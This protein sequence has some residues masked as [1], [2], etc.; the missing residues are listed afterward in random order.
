MENLQS[1]KKETIAELDKNEIG[2]SLGFD[3]FIKEYRRMHHLSDK[4]I[5]MPVKAIKSD[6]EIVAGSPKLQLKKAKIK[7]FFN[8]IYK[9]KSPDEYINIC[10]GDKTNNKEGTFFKSFF[11][12]DLDKLSEF[13]AVHSNAR[14][15]TY[16]RLATTDGNGGTEEHLKYRYSLGF[17]FDNKDFGRELKVTDIYDSVKRANNKFYYHQIVDSGNGYHLYVIITKTD[18]LDRV[19]IL[20]EEL[21]KSLGA[22]SKAVLQTQ[23]LRVPYTYNIKDKVK[24][25]T[26]IIPLEKVLDG[27]HPIKFD[28]L[29]ARYCRKQ[30]VSKNNNL[31]I[32][33]SRLRDTEN[34]TPCLERML[35]E[36]SRVKERTNDLMHIVFLL[37]EQYKYTY[38]QINAVCL[39]WGIKSDFKDNIEYRIKYNYKNVKAPV[40]CKDCKDY[41]K[42]WYTKENKDILLS[43]SDAGVEKEV[44]VELSES[45]AKKLKV[46]GTRGVELL[47]ASSLLVFLVLKTTVRGLERDKIVEILTNPDTND[48]A[49]GESTITKA[50][51]NLE[52]IGYI[53]VEVKKNNKK[54]YKVKK[55]RI[56]PD[57]LFNI[58][59]S[60]VI[61]CINN[62]ITKDE[63]KFY[64]YL[65]YLL[66]KT[67]KEIGENDS[68]S[69]MLRIN[70]ETIS[71]DYGVSQQ[72]I[73]DMIANLRKRKLILISEYGISEYNGFIYYTYTLT[74]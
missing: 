19:G 43:D 37:K 25:V 23:L 48:V 50:L 27:F 67:N 26:P 5:P 6:S 70:Q 31:D 71:K 53:E 35:K 2:S 32:N 28:L 1:I 40:R 38:P 65:K 17:D 51:N 4:P 58:N 46:L 62:L 57:L 36:G 3:N 74:C 47:D 30:G 55:T 20:Q 11:F 59:F 73:S 61:L 29:F 54:Y 41:S 21:R 8:L 22:D 24:P 60:L 63:L 34:L 39:E 45:C 49:L 9:D 33:S 68:T 14:V 44:H 64:T 15:N 69:N 66:H 13:V 52:K 42:C 12:S 7:A 72:R 18:D 56:R 10:I 16:Y